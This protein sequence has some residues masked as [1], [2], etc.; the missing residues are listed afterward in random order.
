L[1]RRVYDGTDY[2]TMKELEAGFANGLAVWN[3]HPTPFTWR[4][5]RWQRRRRRSQYD[6]KTSCPMTH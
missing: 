6:G 4:G 2:R 1:D 5:K 3:T